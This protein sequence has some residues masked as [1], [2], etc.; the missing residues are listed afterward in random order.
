MPARVLGHHASMATAPLLAVSWAHA[1]ISTTLVT[2]EWVCQIRVLP[3]V[4]QL[5]SSRV[6]IK[7]QPVGPHLPALLYCSGYTISY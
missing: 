2:V 1:T 6:G 5:L 7:A 4:A 3:Q